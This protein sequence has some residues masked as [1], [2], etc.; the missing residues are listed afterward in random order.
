V[1]PATGTST[2]AAVAETWHTA[3]VTN[4]NWTAT[5]A[6]QP[7]RYRRE[8]IAGGTVRLDGELL[9]TGAGPWP[10]NTTLASLG[11]A[12]APTANSPF[13]TRSDIAVGAGQ[14][15]VN[16]LGG[17]AGAV[18][19]GQVFTGAGQRLFFTGITYPVD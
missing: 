5:G 6:A 18:Q 13:I 19:N 3:T 10:A 14:D 11:T 1:Q 4:A 17:G 7:L 15:T 16:V 8:G 2:V 9:T 12:Y